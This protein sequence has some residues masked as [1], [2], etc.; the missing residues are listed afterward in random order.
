[1][2]IAALAYFSW[3]GFLVRLNFGYKVMWCPAEFHTM[4]V[5]G[6]KKTLVMR[7]INEESVSSLLEKRDALADCDV[8]VF[9]YDG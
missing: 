6:S 5:K 8:A 9:V 4:D 3:L 2:A 1:M 7:E